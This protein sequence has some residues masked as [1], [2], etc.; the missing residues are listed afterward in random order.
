MILRAVMPRQIYELC[1]QAIEKGK[2]P[3]RGYALMQG[4]EVPVNTPCKLH[5]MK[6]AA[7][8]FGWY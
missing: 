1:R 7:D 6:R 4:C 5:V 3:P 8:D 2:K